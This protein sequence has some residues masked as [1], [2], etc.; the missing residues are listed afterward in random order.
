MK[1]LTM[2]YVINKSN[3][4]HYYKGTDTLIA[5]YNYDMLPMKELVEFLEIYGDDDATNAKLKDDCFGVALR[6]EDLLDH[7]GVNTDEDFLLKIDN[8]NR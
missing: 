2:A 8:V 3:E 6:L 1:N 4:V 7:S 5:F